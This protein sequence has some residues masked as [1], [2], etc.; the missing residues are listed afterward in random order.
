MAVALQYESRNCDI[1]IVIPCSAC[2]PINIVHH[3]TCTWYKAGLLTRGQSILL[4]SWQNC[5]PI[6][7]SG[8]PT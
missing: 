1:D 5:I 8:S 3:I 2:P 7:A 6:D 4:Q